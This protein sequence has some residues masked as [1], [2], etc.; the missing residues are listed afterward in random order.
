MILIN[1]RKYLVFFAWWLHCHNVAFMS[2]FKSLNTGRLEFE[3]KILTLFTINSCLALHLFSFFVSFTVTYKTMSGWSCVKLDVSIVAPTY[4]RRNG[5]LEGAGN[6]TASKFYTKEN[7]FQIIHS[8]VEMLQSEPK[9]HSLSLYES[10]IAKK[11][12]FHIKFAK[13]YK[14]KLKIRLTKQKKSLLRS[15]FIATS[16]LLLKKMWNRYPHLL[17]KTELHG[18]KHLIK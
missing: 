10:D 18:F 8:F 12:L 9:R 2:T 16:T 15:I 3:E 13:D 11:N 4:V 6:T 17:K 5:N 1:S 7:H 14:R